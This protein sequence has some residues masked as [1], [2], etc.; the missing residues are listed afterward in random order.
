MNDFPSENIKDLNAKIKRYAQE[1]L[2]IVIRSDN[3]IALVKIKAK[4]I[5]KLTS[6]IESYPEDVMGDEEWLH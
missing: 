4:Q 5:V 3:T 1:I 6:E 2:G